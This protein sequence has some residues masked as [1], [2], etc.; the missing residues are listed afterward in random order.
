MSSSTIR[1]PEEIG[2]DFLNNCWAD[3][4]KH[5]EIKFGGLDEEVAKIV[6]AERSRYESE[7]L[8]GLTHAWCLGCGSIEPVII[9]RMDGKDVSGNF[10]A[11][12]DVV[13]SVCRSVI[14][15]MYREAKK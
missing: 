10:A 3:R 2:N 1:T 4:R 13:C 9:D 5:P 15:T 8:G 14:A 7:G 11:P 12:T 6:V